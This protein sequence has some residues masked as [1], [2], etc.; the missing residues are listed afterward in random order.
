MIELYEML[1]L[2]DQVNYLQFVSLLF[3]L[4]WVNQHAATLW[5]LIQSNKMNRWVLLCLINFSQEKFL[6]I[7]TAVFVFCRLTDGRLEDDGDEVFFTG[8]DERFFS[9]SRKNVGRSI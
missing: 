2:H 9:R 4:T 3:L 7:L 8:I 6:F 5:V 1:I